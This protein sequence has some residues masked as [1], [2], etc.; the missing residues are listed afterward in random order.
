MNLIATIAPFV[1]AYAILVAAYV[2]TVTPFAIISGIV[3]YRH[4]LLLPAPGSLSIEEDIDQDGVLN[5][6]DVMPN[7]YNPYEWVEQCYSNG[8]GL[9]VW[10]PSRARYK[11]I[12]SS[13]GTCKW[14]QRQKHYIDSDADTVPDICDLCSCG[15]DSADRDGDRIPDACDCCPDM[16]NPAQLCIEERHGMPNCKIDEGVYPSESDSDGDGV[17]NVEDNCPTQVNP[18]QLNDN[19][20]VPDQGNACKCL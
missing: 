11:T 3:T 10:S 5:A 4:N 14:I 20:I 13:R 18:N 2:I 15:D 8:P 19:L 17:L 16:Y 12:L 7:Y 6:V 9:S 1:A